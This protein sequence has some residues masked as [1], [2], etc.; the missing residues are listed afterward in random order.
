MEHICRTIRSIAIVAIMALFMMYV[1][2]AETTYAAD[3]I[4]SEQYVSI[5]APEEWGGMF[6]N[7]PLSPGK[8]YSWSTDPDGGTMELRYFYD[9]DCVE[10]KVD[11]EKDL[12]GF[13][14]AIGREIICKCGTADT[15]YDVVSM[16]I[17]EGKHETFVKIHTDVKMGSGN[18]SYIYYIAPLKNH[19]YHVFTVYDVPDELIPE[20]EKTVCSLNDKGFDQVLYDA[21]KD[22]V[23]PD[24]DRYRDHR[25]EKVIFFIKDY[26]EVVL[27]ALA[28]VVIYV[29][30]KYIW[31]RR[32]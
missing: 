2:F 22:E 28:A 20:C 4:T 1:I 26:D 15:K 7:L 9:G 10:T 12:K 25:M 16:K 23:G 32:R 11:S 3:E 17:L 27:A 31:R 6:D 24:G 14:K 13:L 18:H 21:Y 30:A 19:M 8:Y 5:E 29:V